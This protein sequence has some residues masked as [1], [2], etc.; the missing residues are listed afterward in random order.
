MSARR[1]ISAG[2][3]ATLLATGALVGALPAVAVD[4]TPV[5]D[6]GVVPEL[7]AGN[8]SCEDLGYDFFFK[9]DSNESGLFVIDDAGN[10]IVVVV[11]AGTF[12]EWTS[13]IGIDVVIVKGG[14]NA[15]SY[16]YDPPTES[17]G[18]SGLAA[19]PNTQSAP[20]DDF[21]GLSHV[22]FCFDYE[23][24]VTKDASTSLTRT[25]DWTI[26]KS[27]DQTELTLSAGQSF[28]VN[29]DVAVDATATDSD[30]AVSGTITI[31]NPAPVPATVTDVTDV[32]SLLG[33]ADIPATV[34]CPEDFPFGIAAGDSV[35]CTYAADLPDGSSRLNTATA[36][37]SGPVS[38]D[39]GTATVDFAAAT[40]TD[41]DECID[42]EDTLAGVL[43][44][45]CVGDAPKT[46][47]YQLDVSE[48]L[49]P[50]EDPYAECGDYTVE[51]VASFLTGDTGATGSDDWTIDVSIPCYGGC[52]LTQG[53]WKTHSDR[54]PAPYDPA[55]QNLGPLEEDTLF[56]KSGRTWYDVFWTPP[57]GNA[58]YNLA[59]QY[60]AAKL[61]V[62][63]GADAPASVL[64]ALAGAEA[65]FNAQGLADTTLSRTETT[66]ARQLATILDG[67]NNGLTGPGHC[68][69]DNGPV[70]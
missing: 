13:T 28:L 56:F 64:T 70:S 14:P 39:S 43:G 16:V 32:I 40:V 27:A 49:V 21:Y 55:W 33:E 1:W 69:E 54:G 51:N 45:V 15:N 61:N 20:T 18:D 9:S 47:E 19:P 62:L 5:S 46:F 44:E 65:L 48:F 12:V 3:S 25:W 29:Y 63:D 26:E 24:V 66:T 35:Q 10:E 23:V 38:G 17:L 52:T 8:P 36:E 53:Y 7:V 58:Y 67:Y 22:E 50:S 31:Q 41:V 11:T 68:S 34:D 37:T 59:H 57:A 4:S 30:W 60:M 6:D 42:V 2:A